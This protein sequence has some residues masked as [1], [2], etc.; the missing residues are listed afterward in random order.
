MLDLIHDIEPLFSIVFIII[1]LFR[2]NRAD[3][4]ISK[5]ERVVNQAGEIQKRYW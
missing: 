4:L 5:A 3:R 2:M 1:M